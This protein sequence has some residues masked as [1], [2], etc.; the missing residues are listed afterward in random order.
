MRNKKCKSNKIITVRCKI[1]RS[2]NTKSLCKTY[3]EHS[4]TKIL[5]HYKCIECGTVFIGN[6]INSEELK[7][8]YSYLNWKKYYRDIEIENKKKILTAVCNLKNLLNTSCNIIDIGTGNGLFIDIL[9]KNGFACLFAHDIPGQD[10]SKIRNI[11]KHIYQDFDY[12]SIPS[13]YF[14]A[15]TLLDVAE[16]VIDPRYLF[17]SCYRIL[18]NN[19]IIY[20]HTPVV[21]PLDRLMHFVQKVPI[22][23]KIGRI[24]QRGRT[25]IYHLQ[26]YTKKS[27]TLLLED[28]GF[29]NIDIKIRNELSWPVI[30][31]IKVY[32][33]EKQGLPTFL[34]P[35]VYPVLYPLLATN[36]FN[37]N[38][39]IVIAKKNI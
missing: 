7:T 31:Y 2:K 13:D 24:W 28:C 38:K 39:S 21:T 27:I 30:K 3:N 10:F 18:K 37:S 11:A 19:G 15:V 34:A 36:F 29:V 26:N 33:L 12:N 16:H 35:I 32:L 5:N 9:F 22:I 23:N 8:A 6:D 1:C 4:E 14:S 17:K 20:F 25:S